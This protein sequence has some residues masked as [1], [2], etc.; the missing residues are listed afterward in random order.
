MAFEDSLVLFFPNVPEREAWNDL[1][2]GV[3]E[4]TVVGGCWPVAYKGIQVCSVPAIS[5]AFETDAVPK[6]GYQ[7]ARDHKM[8][9]VFL[10]IG[11]VR[12]A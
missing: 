8:V 5:S 1:P 3:E 9:D 10:R 6:Q 4:S 12:A 11:A 2:Q 7:R